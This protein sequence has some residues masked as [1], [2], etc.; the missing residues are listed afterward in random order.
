MSRTD[1]HSLPL[2]QILELA[3]RALAAESALEQIRNAIGGAPLASRSPRKGR[4]PAPSSSLR[5][6]GQRRASCTGCG[7]ADGTVRWGRCPP[8]RD[9]G[10][11]RAMKSTPA[12]ATTRATARKSGRP[13]KSK[14]TAKPGKAPA[15]S[16]ADGGPIDEIWVTKLRMRLKQEP[17]LEYKPGV[18]AFLRSVFSG[19]RPSRSEIPEALQ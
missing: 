17:D 13:V 5:S 4:P 6:N 9:A 14:K 16:E 19:A 18:P 3:G 2:E 11:G 7:V 12:P 1:L 8:C 15:A 10:K